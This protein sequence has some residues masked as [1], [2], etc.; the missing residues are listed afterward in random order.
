MPE[1]FVVVFVGF[2][3]VAVD[4]DLVFVDVAVV[5][6]LFYAALLVVHFY[7]VFFRGFVV[8]VD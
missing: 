8:V 6:G 4:V 5:V 3:V 7:F 1:S 2:L